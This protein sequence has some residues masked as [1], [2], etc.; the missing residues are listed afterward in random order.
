ML[1]ALDIF[2]IWKLTVIKFI[3]MLHVSSMRL[4]SGRFT[5]AQLVH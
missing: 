5:A 1:S 3:P 2:S 4:T